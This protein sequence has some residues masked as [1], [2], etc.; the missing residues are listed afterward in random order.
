MKKFIILFV[1]TAN[2]GFAQYKS[3]LEKPVDI[4]AGITNY[5]P[6]S[7]FLGF[8]NLDNLEMH[9]S[10]SMSYGASAN[11]GIALSTYT[12]S[13]FYKF[14]DNLNL[15]IDASIVNTPYNTLG[16]SF[17]NSI[18]GI[19][20]SRAQLNYK[21]SE[22]TNIVLQFRSGPGSYYNPYNYYSGINRYSFFDDYLPYGN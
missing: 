19:Y 6:S 18:N 20:L 13:L 5:N 3:D 10:L 11:Y 17:T 12:N 4:K 16:D 15:E 22:N 9:H 14:S 8:I 1:I 7:L 21:P 2:L